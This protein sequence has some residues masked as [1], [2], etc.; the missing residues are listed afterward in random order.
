M[1]GTGRKDTT[2]GWKWV[3]SGTVLL[4]TAALVATMV[5]SVCRGTRVVDADYYDHGLHYD[6]RQAS[7]RTGVADGWRAD[8]SCAG[9]RLQLC[10]ID[11]AGA[12]GR[13]ATVTFTPSASSPG[14]SVALVE[15]NPGT[16]TS[17]TLSETCAVTGTMTVVRGADILRRRVA[18][19]R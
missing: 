4:F 8:V 1:T 7:D 9:G 16:Y 5:F 13:G 2:H 12:P 3:I 18:V 11:G 17:S 10:L 15:G 19:I 14:G 6:A